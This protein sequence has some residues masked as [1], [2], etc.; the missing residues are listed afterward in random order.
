[1]RATFCECRLIEYHEAEPLE[2]RVVRL[3]LHPLN[4]RM[5]GV[6]LERGGRLGRLVSRDLQQLAHLMSDVA[7]ADHE[8]SGG[9]REAVAEAHFVDALSQHAL[10]ALQQAL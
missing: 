9:L 4:Q 2:T 8:A 7:F 1:E 10:D 3:A 5:T 6:Q